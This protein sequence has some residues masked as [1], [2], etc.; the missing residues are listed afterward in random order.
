MNKFIVP[1][2]ILAS[3]MIAATAWSATE[4]PGS[5]FQP[6]PYFEMPLEKDAS[7]VVRL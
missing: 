3:G 4:Q 6:K 7:R 5:G 1:A 2:I